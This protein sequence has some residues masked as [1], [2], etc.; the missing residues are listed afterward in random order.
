MR[1]LFPGYPEAA[2]NTARIADMCN[3]DFTFGVYHLPEYRLPEGE[4]DSK[5]YLRRLCE[6]GLRRRYG[7]RAAEMKPRLDHELNIINSMGF[8]DYFLVV[9]DYV[10]YAK[11]HDIPV[12]PGRG[13]SAGSIVSYSLN[14]TDVDPIRY[15]L[16]FERFLN[17]ERVS[18]P[19]IDI[20]FCEA[21]RGELSTMSGANT[22]KTMWPR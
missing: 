2:D 13:S 16:M 6:E 4:T 22:A 7:G 14:I 8:T 10:N 9:W 21:R 20:D 15:D 19:D 3:L 12:G 18:M 17:P 1:A 5:A 11:T